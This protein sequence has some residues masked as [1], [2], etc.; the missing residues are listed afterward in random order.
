MM[1]SRVA[2]SIYWM[3]R[4]MERAD[5]V[6]RFIDVNT[7]LMLD[8]TL[9]REATQWY[10]LVAT[11]GDDE[12]FS[13]RYKVA[14]ER[15]VLRFLTFDQKNPNSI[16]HCIYRA[17]ENAR[18]VREVLPVDVWEKINELYHLTQAHSRKRSV[19]DLMDYY[20]QVRRTGH[21]MTGLMYNT[22]SRNQGWQFAHLGQM[23]ERADKTARLLDVKYFLLLP[24]ASLLDTPFDAVQWGAVLKSVHAL[25]MYRQQ[26]HTINY[27]DVTQFLLFEKGFPR[28]VAFCLDEAARTMS[29]LSQGIERPN[30]AIIEMAIL[31]QTIAASEATQIIATGLHEF[32][33]VLQYNMNLVDEAI[34][35]SFFKD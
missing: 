17:R 1:L 3:A 21:L 4:Y 33:D 25:E 14:D 23:L 9:N 31:T 34:Y 28:S 26:F 22:M 35:E 10:P 5:N 29:S 24:E 15:N 19:A 12:T 16:L 2:N 27:K 13:K 7:H 11:S 20:T 18:T 30:K 32:I 6:A 8:L